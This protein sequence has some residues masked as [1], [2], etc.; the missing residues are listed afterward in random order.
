MKKVQKIL[1]PIDFA[2]HFETMLP[3]V[4]T[5]ADKFGATVYVV[6]VTQDLSN[7]STFY[8]PHGN[9]QS[10]QQEALDSARKRMAAVKQEFFSKFPSWKPG[11]NWG[12]PR[13]RSWSWPKKR[14][15]I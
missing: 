4:S 10:F 12:L 14:K 11:W 9:I 13:K 15:S 5:L 8:V 7:F 6:F 2:A 3:W 1:F